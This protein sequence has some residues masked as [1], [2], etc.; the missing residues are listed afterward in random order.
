M[1]LF[2]NCKLENKHDEVICTLNIVVYNDTII[3]SL[4][5][6]SENRIFSSCPIKYIYEMSVHF[7]TTWR[8]T[9]QLPWTFFFL[10]N[11]LIPPLGGCDCFRIN[12]VNSHIG[13][14]YL[15]TCGFNKSTE[16]LKCPQQTKLISFYCFLYWFFFSFG[17]LYAIRRHAGLTCS[18]S[19]HGLKRPSY[20]IRESVYSLRDRKKPSF[21]L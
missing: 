6:K 5:C 18:A 21:L 7:G 13:L 8:Q 10:V 3:T 4:G 9:Y 19:A 17:N 1:W 11:L 12:S 14:I 16:C 2:F 15:I 20:F